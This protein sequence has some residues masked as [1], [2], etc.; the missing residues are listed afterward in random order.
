MR[1]EP[2]MS[3]GEPWQHSLAVYRNDGVE[4]PTRSV[5]SAA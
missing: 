2:A 1:I 5:L 3:S 4:G